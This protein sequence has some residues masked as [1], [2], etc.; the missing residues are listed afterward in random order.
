MN[1]SVHTQKYFSF[2]CVCC[3]IFYFFKEKCI[4]KVQVNFVWDAYIFIGMYFKNLMRVFFWWV[5]NYV[6]YCILFW[7][8]YNCIDVNVW[9]LFLALVVFEFCQFLLRIWKKRKKIILR[10]AQ[11]LPTTFLFMNLHMNKMPSGFCIDMDIPCLR[12]SSETSSAV[13]VATGVILVNDSA[14]NKKSILTQHFDSTFLWNCFNLVVILII[15]DI[16]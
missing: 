14:I 10:I 3:F 15:A 11:N 6:L 1:V 4:L 12:D 2:C 13:L 7:L 8:A 16:V 5:W 9:I